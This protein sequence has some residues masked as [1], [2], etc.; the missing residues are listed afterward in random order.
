MGNLIDLTGQ[1]FDRLTVIK[2]ADDYVR[3]NGQH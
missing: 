1:T 2:R 3:P